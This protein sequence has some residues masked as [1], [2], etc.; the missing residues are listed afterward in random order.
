[1]ILI[2]A[3]SGI[4]GTVV[5]TDGVGKCLIMKLVYGDE[6]VYVANIHAPTD[7]KEKVVFF[8]VLRKKVH[9]FGNLILIGD[10]NMVF[11][12]Q[13]MADGM[14]FISDTGRKALRSLMDDSNLVDVWRDCNMSKRE[15]SR[16]QS[17]GLCLSNS[18]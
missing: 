18:D 11:S 2:R 16:F 14:V 8:T 3:V 1:M 5:Y 10:F 9:A 13:D 17:R 4:K 15:F 12:A 7:Q 6:F